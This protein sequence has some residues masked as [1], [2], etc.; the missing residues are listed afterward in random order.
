MPSRGSLTQPKASPTAGPWPESVLPLRHTGRAPRRPL[1]LPLP[2]SSQPVPPP[3]QPS[4]RPRPRPS[5]LG[6]F[7]PVTP[8]ILAPGLALAFCH[9]E[10]E[11]RT[12]LA[13]AGLGGPRSRPCFPLP[14]RGAATLGV[15]REEWNV[16]TSQ[17][18]WE[19]SLAPRA[20][21]LI[22]LPSPPV[23]SY[24]FRSRTNI[25][26]KG[27]WGL[28]DLGGR[29]FRSPYSKTVPH[30]YTTGLSD[31]GTLITPW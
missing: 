2:K 17:S 3:R 11:D 24:P 1:V 20:R 25:Q 16:V 4:P 7:G 13:G 27:D 10:L 23:F 31:H 9:P 18:P 29:G 8:G 12:P 19:L 30:P 21:C 14:H 22:L 15:G 5:P 28:W 26:I 6:D